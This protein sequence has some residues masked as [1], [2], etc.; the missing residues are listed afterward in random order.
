MLT[1]QLEAEQL[2]VLTQIISHR[3]MMYGRSSVTDSTRASNYDTI[4]NM[5]GVQEIER[6]IRS[7]PRTEVERLHYWLENYLEDQLE[8]S[9]EFHAKIDRGKRDIA[10]G[11]VRIRRHD[12][13]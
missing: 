10:E 7:L 1:G 8:I 5:S 6:A 4:E 13:T 11:H 2:V 3:H 9:G 12:E